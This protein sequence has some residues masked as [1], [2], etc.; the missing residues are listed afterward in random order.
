MKVTHKRSTKILRKPHIFY[1]LSHIN[2][3]F[4]FFA[5]FLIDYFFIVF[6]ERNG[7]YL[8]FSFF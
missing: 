4:M 6:L 5:S 2:A 7:L 8:T 3:Q 1:S